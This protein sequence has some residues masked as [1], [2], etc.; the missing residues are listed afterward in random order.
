[1]RK[2]IVRKT[3]IYSVDWFYNGFCYRTTM[4]CKWED[5][6]ECKRVAKLL[7]EEIKYEHYDTREEVYILQI[8]KMM[9]VSDIKWVT[10]GEVVEL[11]TEVEVNDNLSDDQIA[12]YLSDTYGWLVEG[13]S[14]PMDDDDIDEFGIYVNEV[15]GKVS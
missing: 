14:L 9:I 8:K 13:F 12:D 3:K 15:E 10:D 2:K 5:V 7:G 11:P 4:G 1:M 6:K